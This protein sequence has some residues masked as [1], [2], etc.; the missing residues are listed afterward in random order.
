MGSQFQYL[1]LEL[2][3]IYL[4]GSTGKSSER[5]S[6]MAVTLSLSLVGLFQEEFRLGTL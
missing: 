2:G 6:L 5:G 3:G 4:V 1:E